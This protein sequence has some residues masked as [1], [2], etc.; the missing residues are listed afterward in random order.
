MSVHKS[1]APGVGGW[2]RGW[3]EGW[4]WQGLYKMITKLDNLDAIHNNNYLVIASSASWC[5]GAEDTSSLLFLLTITICCTL[6]SGRDHFSIL[7]PWRT[8]LQSFLAGTKVSN[9]RD[10][11]GPRMN[12]LATISLLFCRCPHHEARNNMLFL[13]ALSLYRFPCKHNSRKSFHVEC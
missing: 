12:L 2:V 6:A 5:V 1:G 7:K 13:T 4:V 9:T 10:K 8:N 3:V 11:S